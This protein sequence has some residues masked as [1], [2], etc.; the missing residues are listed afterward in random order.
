MAAETFFDIKP[1]ENSIKTEDFELSVLVNGKPRDIFMLNNM[2]NIVPEVGEEFEVKFSNFG[3]KEVMTSLIIDGVEVLGRGWTS[4]VSSKGDYTFK[5]F[6]QDDNQIASFAFAP[7]DKEAGP[8]TSKDKNVTPDPRIG[9]ITCNVYNCVCIGPKN[10]HE[11]YATKHPVVN[12]DNTIIS[13]N[14]K[15]ANVITATGQTYKDHSIISKERYEKKGIIM[16]F[17]NSIQCHRRTH[18]N[19]RIR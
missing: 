18:S 16:Y 9:L 11:Y 4:I 17:G 1:T 13:K 3:D 7:L 6:S 19:S 12:K 10:T 2:A 14:K 5:G 15:K 8:F